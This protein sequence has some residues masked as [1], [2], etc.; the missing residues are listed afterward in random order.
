MPVLNIKDILHQDI[1]N[2]ESVTMVGEDF[3]ILDAPILSPSSRFPYR[4]E[5]LIA[6]LCE[7]GSA[8]GS[9]NLRN[10]S[11][12]AGGFIIILP[13]QLVA[14]SEVSDDFEGK[15]VL[16]SRHF[17][18]SLDIGRTLSLT[19]SIVNQPYYQ[20]QGGAIDIVRSYISTCQAMIR[21]NGDNGTIREVL[22]LLARAFFLGAKPLL[23]SREDSLSVGPYSKL[24][25][26]FLAMVEEDYRT[27]RRLDHYAAKLGRNTKYLSRHIKEETG[28]NASDWIDR[29]VILDAQARLLSTN[30]S[31]REISESLGFPTQ[32]FFG[33]YFKRVIGMTPKEY[34]QGR[35]L[36]ER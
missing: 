15:V 27:E 7:S 14:R 24:T 23:T 28:R 13:G 19:A 8:S 17:A 21:Q 31:I 33:K 36:P 11:I 25:E 16:M 10:Y 9:I 6:T 34:R 29:C 2:P 22:R 12:G 5:W 32:S 20:F 3:I 30:D 4:N 18:E 1:L 35:K 26:E